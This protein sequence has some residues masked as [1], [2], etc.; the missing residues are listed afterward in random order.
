MTH[1][2]A[3]LRGKLS[4]VK[5]DLVWA[6]RHPATAR[7]ALVAGCLHATVLISAFQLMFPHVSTVHEAV[8]TAVTTLV[9]TTGTFLATNVAVE[10]ADDI[11][12]SESP[13]TT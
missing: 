5:R 7:K 9:T 6:L 8:F 1:L 10:V 4:V 13:G 12:K 2:E 3:Y 11:Q